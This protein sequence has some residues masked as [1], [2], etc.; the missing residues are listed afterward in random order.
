[1]KFCGNAF[2]VMVNTCAKI[3]E[4]EGGHVSQMCQSVTKGDLNI[5]F[6]N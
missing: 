2:L 4:I 5:F 3:K 1:M 6:V